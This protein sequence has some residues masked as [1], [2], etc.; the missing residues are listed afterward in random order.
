[1]RQPTRRG[2]GSVEGESEGIHAGGSPDLNL[3]GFF[4]FERGSLK[5]GLWEQCEYSWDFGG[6]S[7]PL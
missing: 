2:M 7:G 6:G 1:V 3:L 5:F 4:Y